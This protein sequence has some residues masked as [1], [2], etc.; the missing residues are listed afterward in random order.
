MSRRRDVAA[1][2]DKLNGTTNSSRES[3]TPRN[4]IKWLESKQSLQG[5]RT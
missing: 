4:S 2:T 5:V 1:A 3:Q